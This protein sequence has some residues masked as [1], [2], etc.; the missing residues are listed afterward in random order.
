M[1][2]QALS[3][4]VSGEVPKRMGN[5][6]SM[7]VPWSAFSTTDDAIIVAV[8]NDG[9]FARMADAIGL[10]GLGADARYATNAARVSHRAE[11]MPLLQGALSRQTAA[12]W[13]QTFEAA[14]VPCGP[15]CNMQQ[16]F[17]QPQVILERPVHVGFGL[18]RRPSRTA[19]VKADGRPVCDRPSAHDR[20]L[21]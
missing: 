3:Y 19:R 7:I 21:P 2:D 17:E 15:V 20:V 14:G 10:A 8:G 5:D 16:V 11:L 4:L 12:H 18:S 9:Q 1:A 13:I 6:H